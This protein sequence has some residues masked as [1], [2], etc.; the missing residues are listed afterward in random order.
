MTSKASLT[1]KISQYL[2]SKAIS[3]SNKHKDKTNSIKR[4]EISNDNF[5]GKLSQSTADVTRHLHQTHRR[6]FSEDG[7]SSSSK[8]KNKNKNAFRFSAITSKKFR[9]VF[10]VHEM[11]N[12][13]TLEVFIDKLNKNSNQRL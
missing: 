11:H 13:K 7:N 2:N 3:N 9:D 6:L 1:T 4:N 12:S 8:N 10:G 5:F